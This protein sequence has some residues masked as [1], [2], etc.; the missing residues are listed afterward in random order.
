[1]GDNSGG[2]YE[3]ITR[4]ENEN[5]SLKSDIQCMV[6]KAAS[7]HLPAY[8]EQG[9]KLLYVTLRAEEAEAERDKMHKTLTTASHEFLAYKI[10]C[11][12]RIKELQTLVDKYLR[13]E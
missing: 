6:E 4:L 3:A 7:K 11:V 12:K 9:E 10:E 13:K 5:E 1:M 2:L 8:R